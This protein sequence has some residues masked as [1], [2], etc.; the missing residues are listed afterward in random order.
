MASIVEKHVLLV[1]GYLKTDSFKAT[2][3]EY[4]CRFDCPAPAKSVIWESVKQF[5]QTGNVNINETLSP[6]YCYSIDL[7][8]RG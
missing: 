8:S 4:S 1:E 2:Q 3:S 7:N 5:R 6:V